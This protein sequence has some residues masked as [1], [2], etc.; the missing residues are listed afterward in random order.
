M[1]LAGGWYPL[2]GAWAGGGL[3]NGQQTCW[4]AANNRK[5][6]SSRGPTTPA[7]LQVSFRQG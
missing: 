3:P 4:L 2:W 7:A 6:I 5:G 1:S